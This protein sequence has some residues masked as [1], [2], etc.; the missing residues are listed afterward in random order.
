MSEKH[1][2]KLAELLE[3]R[4][5]ESDPPMPVGYES[6]LDDP[7][8]E[9]TEPDMPSEADTRRARLLRGVDPEIAALISDDELAE[10][11]AEEQ[12]KA[13]EAKKASALKLVRAHMAQQAKAD[14]GL[15]PASVLLSEAERRRQNE[16]VT[17]RINMPMHGGRL[18]GTGATWGMRINGEEFQHGMTY[19]RPRH[20]F[21]SLRE[22]HYRAHLAHVQ[23]SDLN[24][25]KVYRPGDDARGISP[26]QLLLGNAPPVFEMVAH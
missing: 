3:G 20:I 16:P 4:P 22:M 21:D 6:P 11:E 26:A 2:Q 14:A 12:R 7:P 17:F 15:I 8:P 23:F 18:A 9:V 19:T 5:Q 13:S 10:I 24:Q 25:D 1:R